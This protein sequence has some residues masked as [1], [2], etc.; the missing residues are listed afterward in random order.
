MLNTTRTVR[1]TQRV[2]RIGVALGTTRVCTADSVVAATMAAPAANMTTESTVTASPLMVSLLVAWPGRGH[3]PPRGSVPAAPRPGS[4]WP[5]SCGPASRANVPS[6]RA[7]PD[8]AGRSTGCSLRR[9]PPAPAP[10]APGCG[11]SP[12]GAAASPRRAPAGPP[13]RPPPA[14]SPCSTPEPYGGRTPSSTCRNVLG[15]RPLTCLQ[16]GSLAP[17]ASGL[18][19]FALLACDHLVIILA[20]AGG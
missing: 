14:W 8:R 2:S 12:A 3:A 13:S 17:Q 10:P 20:L 1:N 18:G 16:C 15:P 4:P 9:G 11:S 5:R 7:V 6:A 19:L